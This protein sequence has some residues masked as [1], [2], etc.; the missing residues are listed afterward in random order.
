MRHHDFDIEISHDVAL[1]IK[2]HLIEVG[3]RQHKFYST[4][5]VVFSKNGTGPLSGHVRIIPNQRSRNN[6][7]I[8][9]TYSLMFQVESSIALYRLSKKMSFDKK[10]IDVIKE[11]V[12][13]KDS[14]LFFSEI[15]PS[16]SDEEQAHYLF[17][18]DKYV[19]QSK[20]I[21]YMQPYRFPVQVR[22]I[23]DKNRILSTYRSLDFTREIKVESPNFDGIFLP[24]V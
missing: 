12:L 11:G 23:N 15:L 3:F 9:P 13:R 21:S 18:I 24:Q 16:L 19:G 5:S 8:N 7:R 2:R 20:M 22:S 6:G 10:L 4:G 17:N 14:E 1:K